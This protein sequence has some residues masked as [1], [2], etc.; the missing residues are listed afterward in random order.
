MA[1]S[2]YLTAGAAAALVEEARSLQGEHLKQKTLTILASVKNKASK[3][4]TTV[5]FYDVES[6]NQV[7]VDRLKS[8]GYTVTVDRSQRDGDSL[9]VSWD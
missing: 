4:E 7:I 8:L 2:E 3:G 6:I 5:S 9:T 1:S